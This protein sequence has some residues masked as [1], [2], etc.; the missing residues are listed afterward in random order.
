[1][2]SLVIKSVSEVVFLHTISKERDIE[3]GMQY[4][5]PEQPEE[6]NGTVDN[7][8]LNSFN[9]ILS[10]FLLIMSVVLMFLYIKM[11][12]INTMI[13]ALISYQYRKELLSSQVLV[14]HIV[15]LSQ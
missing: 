11:C 10:L 12:N 5:L 7:Y 14:K 4:V 2:R 6:K 9:E 13:N 3:Q 15:S 1:M 8:P